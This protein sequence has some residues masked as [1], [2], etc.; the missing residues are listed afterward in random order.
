MSFRQFVINN[1]RRNP[2]VYGPY[3]FTSFFAVTMFFVYALLVF[4][5]EFK[6]SIDSSSETMSYFAM[7]GFQVSQVI[8]VIFSAFAIFYAVS[9]FLKTRKA[10]FGLLLIQGINKKQ[11][12]KLIFWENMLAGL[13]AV[14]CGVIF[15][16]I[17]SKVILLICSKILALTETLPFYFPWK[18]ILLTFGVFGLMFLVISF[19]TSFTIRVNNL[20]ALLAS[21][22]EP[23]KE[24]K[25]A[26]Y[27]AL[28]ALVLITTGYGIVLIFTNRESF[29]LTPL[30]TGVILVVIGTYFFFSQL[31]VFMLTRLRKRERFFFKRTNLLTFSEL[32]YQ[33]R[34]NVSTFFIVAIISATAITAM[35]T[36]SA[37]GSSGLAEMSEN[38]YAITYTGYG[39]DTI[40]KDIISY[41]EKTLQGDSYK[42]A[43]G[44]FYQFSDDTDVFYTF[45]SIEDYN[46]LMDLRNEAKIT[47]P[48]GTVVLLPTESLSELH[49]KS[50]APDK[51]EIQLSN[52]KTTLPVEKVAPINRFPYASSS[53][54]VEIGTIIANQAD[55][56]ALWQEA[57]VRY[58]NPKDNYNSK[59]PYTIFHMVDWESTAASAKKLQNNVDSWNEKNQDSDKGIYTGFESLAI[60]WQTMQQTNGL[61]LLLTVLCGAVFY[62]FSAGFIYLRLHSDLKRDEQQYKMLFKIGLTK[63]ELHKIVARQLRVMFFL[64]LFVAVIHSLVAF[65]ALQNLLDFNIWQNVGIV[66]GIFIAV[67]AIYYFFVKYQYLKQL[68]RIMK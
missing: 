22:K 25:A 3:F 46:A 30:F 23:K 34:D 68:R 8:I 47:T 37:I 17:F 49:L 39:Q 5:P 10:E 55:I 33:M 28:L 62:T 54:S 44:H 48:P 56:D 29:A 58:K 1:V 2:K 11:L 60:Q 13:S 4:H 41:T 20:K 59:I 12:V 35:G 9:T 15:G 16:F 52:Q 64:P 43:N 24:I 36:S 42:R 50:D 57:E 51:I 26:W 66:I 40:S 38:P 27:I 31:L 6:D 21:Q 14:V 18:P 53:S 32:I 63:S 67:Q 19:V 61:L 65:L 45:L 7:I